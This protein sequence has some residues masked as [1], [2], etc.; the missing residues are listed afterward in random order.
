MLRQDAVLE[1]PE[2]RGL[3]AHQKQR[4][5]QCGDAVGEKADGTEEH[6]RR[7][8]E[9]Q[10]PDHRGLVEAVG[11]LTGEGAEQEERKDEE[12]SRAVDQGVG[13]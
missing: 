7:F 6:H 12:C 10:R 1:R 11:Q 4:A 8:G 13:G 2:E 3:G 5:K 9:F